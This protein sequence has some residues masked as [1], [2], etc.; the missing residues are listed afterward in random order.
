MSDYLLCNFHNV[1]SCDA[2]NEVNR[3]PK[4]DTN[5]KKFFLK[6]SN[7]TGVDHLPLF[8]FIDVV[9]KHKM[10]GEQHDMYH[11]ID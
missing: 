5:N 4:I 2:F 1:D 10:A 8:L 3:R 11:A 9:S 7:K 6:Y